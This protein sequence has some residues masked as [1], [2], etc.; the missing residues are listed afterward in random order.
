MRATYKGLPCLKNPF[1]FALY[2]RLIQSVR[3]RTIIELGS[4]QG[5]SALW[6]AD[7]LSSLDIDGQVYSI[8]VRPV[9]TL[10]DPRIHFLRGDVLDL[11]STLP[12]RLLLTL[13]RPL[14]VIEDSAHLYETTLAVLRFFDPYLLPGEY[15]LV[16]DGIVNDMAALGYAHYDDGPNRAIFDFLAETR[17]RYLIDTEYCDFYGY[18]I[19]YNTNGYIRKL[20]H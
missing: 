2:T 12:V 13:P 6:L 5:G 3:P 14:L 9:E 10:Q 15:L 19:T 20:A 7:L 17:G 18:N 1:D 4:H 16:E 8:D 11:A